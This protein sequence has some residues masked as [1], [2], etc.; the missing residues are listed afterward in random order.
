MSLPPL[1]RTV[2]IAAGSLALVFADP[3]TAPA[4]TCLAPDY[5][6]GLDTPLSVSPAYPDLPAL[7]RLLQLEAEP[8]PT[9][10]WFA[11]SQAGQIWRF[12]DS[13]GAAELQLVLD[14]SDRIESFG[15]AGLLGFAFHP[16]YP[17]NG[18]AFVYYSPAKNLT[19]LSRITLRKGVYLADSEKVLLEFPQPHI[20]HNG[21]GLGFGPDGYLYL[22][23]GDGGGGDDVFGHGQNTHS[24]LATLLRIDVDRGDP[25]AIPADNPFADGR[26]GRPEIYAWGLRNTWRWSF[27]PGTGAI[28]GGDVGQANW[29][30]INR[31]ERGGNYGWPAMEGA[32]CRQERCPQQYLRPRTSYPHSDGRCAVIG[33]HVY[34]GKVLEGFSGHYVY[35]DFCSGQVYGF[36]VDRP[37]DE[38]RLLAVSGIRVAGFSRDRDGEL[39]LLNI[40]GGPGEGVYRLVAGG[41][42]SPELPQRY[43]A[44]ACSESEMLSYSL[45]QQA[46]NGGLSACYFASLPA[47]K[48]VLPGFEGDLVFPPRSVLIKHLYRD[49]QRLETQLLMHHLTGWAGYSYAW[50]T[51]GSEAT[52]V[53]APGAEASG[54]VINSR[55]ECMYCHNRAARSVL[56]ADIAQ[57]ADSGD[58]QKL[59][60][61]KLLG[62]A[63]YVP[64]RYTRTALSGPDSLEARARRYL[65]VNCSGCHRP[66]GAPVNMDLRISTP[67]TDAG[68]CG[69]P[70]ISTNLG[71]EDAQLLRPGKSAESLLYRRMVE[72]GPYRMPPVSV[73]PQDRQ[74]AEMI[75]GWIDSLKRC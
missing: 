37:Q 75:K 27:D 36:P 2:L 54:H 7:P 44:L 4:E 9:A 42:S 69:A 66:G 46:W 19:R 53:A 25:Y 12:A 18:L 26:Q 67:L 23:L 24:L 71:L 56:G 65:H 11:V 13:P 72:E 3:A 1:L 52:L 38:A 51:D 60:D 63:D 5:R 62:F 14:W 17:E 58:L 33:G 31:I 10:A 47:G 55:G 20:N 8:G 30:E 74:G 35:G 50:N 48:V 41:S 45:S 49:G 32:H 57:F 39:L 59:K 29:E 64:A 61:K 28:W 22:S 68:L 43:S 15:E 6:A 16:D 34:R 40:D 21:G 70:A 73:G